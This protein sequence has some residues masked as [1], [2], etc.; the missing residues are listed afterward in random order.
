MKQNQFGGTIGGA[1]IK[2]KLFYFGS[3]QGTRQVDGE[4]AASL[5]SVVLPP[6]TSNRSAAD[7]GSG[8]LRAERER[9]AGVAVAC[10]GSNINPIAL[11]LLNYKLPNGQYFIPTPQMIQSNGTGLSVFSIPSTY[12]ENQ[13]M[14]NTDYVISDKQQ[15]S[16]RVI[17]GENAGSAELH[18]GQRARLRNRRTVSQRQRCSQGYL[19]GDSKSHQ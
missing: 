19:H 2:H 6:L 3:Y 14:V 8:I 9:M 12:S 4:G 11:T 17:L 10:D 18:D 7:A 16:E 13:Y 15:L 1:I 5:E